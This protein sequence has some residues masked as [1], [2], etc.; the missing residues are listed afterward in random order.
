MPK[1]LAWLSALL[2]VALV[3]ACGGG[4]TGGTGIIGVSLTDAPACGFDAVNVTVAKVRVHQSSSANENDAGWTDI[5]LNP[6]RKINLLNLTNGVLDGLGDAPLA[7]GHYTQLRLVLSPNT[8]ANPLANSIIPTGGVETAL[9]TPSA[10]HSGI[11]LV[12]EFDV[13][14][15][16]RVDLV[17][18]FNACKSIVKRGNGTYALKPVIK[19]LPFALNGISGFVN[20]ALLGSNIMV[21]AQQNGNVVQST[22]PNALTGEFLL[23]RLALGNYDV[24]FS[25]DN[26]AAAVITTVPV[27]NT[28]S[29]VHV[30]SNI[31]P[32]TLPVS[33]TRIVGGTAILSPASP[34]EV[35]YMA[36]Q[37]TFGTSPIVT[38]NTAAADDLT[39]TYTLTLPVAAPLLGTYSTMLPITFNPQAAVAGQY[40]VE[41]SATG[42]LSQSANV[43]ISAVDAVQNFTL[44]P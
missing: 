26:H 16:Y 37:Q 44:V 11:K 42:Y 18:D 41:A 17:L 28:T 34:T 22:L 30:S 38:T 43:D 29:V 2:L 13:T 39:S 9:V 25:A 3:A 19:V 35:A 33:A 4:N 40:S 20:P 1:F 15:G 23:S 14:A 8:P 21:S 24:V 12:N 10:A 31:A 7:A 32:I 6:A 5:T 36:A 27:T